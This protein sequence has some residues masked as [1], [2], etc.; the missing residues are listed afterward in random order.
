MLKW[1]GTLFERLI[2]IAGALLLSQMPLFMLQY[3]H[4][5]SGHVAELQ[6]QVTSISRVATQGGKNL[7][8]F[9][10][11]FIRSADPDFHA[12]GMLMKGMVQRWHQLSDGLTALQQAAV[13]E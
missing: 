9:V 10:E 11:K 13:W 12:Q 2:G 7:D 6:T 4:E 3:T 5:L 8:S 1:F